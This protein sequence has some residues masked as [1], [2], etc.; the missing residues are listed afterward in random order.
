MGSH[1]E[2]RSE[3]NVGSTFVFILTLPVADLPAVADAAI[4]DTG[5]A[6]GPVVGTGKTILVVDDYAPN[7]MVATLMLENL[8]YSVETAENGEQ[9]LTLLTHGANP[10][11]A[12]LMDVQMYGMDGYETTRRVRLL[13]S[14]KGYRTPIIGVTAH[15][16]QGDR[17]RCLS[18]GM[19]DYLTKPIHPDLLAEKIYSHIQR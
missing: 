9:A 11:T 16:L 15:A 13:E 3:Q 2:V 1:I 19:D 14:Q 17:E 8:G 10:Y 4:Q 18:A 7:I 6:T 5:Q 12:I